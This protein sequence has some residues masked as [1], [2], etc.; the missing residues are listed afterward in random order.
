MRPATSDV[1]W[2]ASGPEQ[3]RTACGVR[4]RVC[5]RRPRVVSTVTISKVVYRGGSR[6]PHLMATCCLGRNARNAHRQVWYAVPP[7]F[8]LHLPDRLGPGPHQIQRF[9][10]CP[11][12]RAVRAR[13]GS[14]PPE[15]SDPLARSR[16]PSPPTPLVNACACPRLRPPA[17]CHT[18]TRLVPVLE[19]PGSA[20]VHAPLRIPD[21]RDRSTRTPV[22]ARHITRSC[23]AA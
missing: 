18:V 21:A 3:R 12:C 7:S 19:P 6:R 2:Q 11:D 22:A 23:D 14:P 5:Y 20:C 16:I 9:S 13:C 4:Q 15:R 8:S 17:R 10:T 1:R